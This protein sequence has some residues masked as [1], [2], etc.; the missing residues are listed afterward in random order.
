[1]K[2][3]AI[4]DLHLSASNPKPMDIFG[5]IWKEHPEKIADNWK[6]SITGEDLV[7]IPGDISWAMKIAEA[8]P[9]F[10][11]LSGLPGRKVLVRGNHDYYWNG[12][13]RLRSKLP[14]D[15]FALQNDSF[16]INDEYAICGSRG[17]VVPGSST[18]EEERDEHVFVR[19]L[20]RMELSIKDALRKGAEKIIMAL[21]YPPTN[22]FHDKS[23]VNE[24]LE[25][26]PVEICLFAHLHNAYETAFQGRMNGIEYYLVSADYLNF[27]PKLVKELP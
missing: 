26:Y 15:I 8:K 21:H 12:I 4:G 6:R 25:E 5:N 23:K 9:D 13:G 19:E 11:W 18:Y 1:M 7:I 22:E 24:L 10:A 17:W 14:D 3:F 2:I 16:L 27:K 20:N